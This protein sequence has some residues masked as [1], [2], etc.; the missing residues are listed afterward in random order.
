MEKLK[1]TDK[2]EYYIE[3]TSDYE[4]GKTTLSSSQRQLLE[5]I[6]YILNGYSDNYNGLLRNYSSKG[7]IQVLNAQVVAKLDNKTISLD[8]AERTKILIHELNI[9]INH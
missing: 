1:K 3:G 4:A 5:K 8:E 7:L 2:K 9:E 6:S